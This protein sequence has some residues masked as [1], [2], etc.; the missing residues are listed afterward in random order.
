M[1]ALSDFQGTRVTCPKGGFTLWLE[2]PVEVDTVVLYAQATAMK[3]TM[4]PGK[5]FSTREKYK[6]CLRL[7]SAFWSE[8]NRW[9][10]E[11]L[12]KLSAQLVDGPSFK[13]EKIL[14]N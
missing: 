12:G 7:N 1:C 11:C 5:L 8:E 6:N 13:A 10:I 14:K 4:A 3:I 9:A 2:L